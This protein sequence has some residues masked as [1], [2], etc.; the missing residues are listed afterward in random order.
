MSV[1]CECCVLSDIFSATSWSLVQRSPTDC[2]VSQMCV[3]MKPRRNEEAQA[4][5][6]LSRHKKKIFGS[7]RHLLVD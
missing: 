3:I 6:R 7:I 4:H 5:I 2:G 1:S